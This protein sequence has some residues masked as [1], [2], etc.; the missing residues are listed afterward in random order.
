MTCS[1]VEAN[2]GVSEVRCNHS[3]VSDAQGSNLV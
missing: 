2:L 1:L 3:E